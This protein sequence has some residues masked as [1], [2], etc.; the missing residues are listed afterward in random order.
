MPLSDRDYMKPQPPEPR[1][2]PVIRGGSGGFL[3]NPVYIIIILNI[4]VYVA[5]LVNSTKLVTTFGLMPATFTQEPWTLVTNMFVHVEI[6]HILGNMLMLFFFGRVVYQLI[7]TKWFL[8]IYF[9]GG[10]AGNLLYVWLGE[11]YA[12]AIG[13]SA[14]IYALAG[15]LVVMMP[16]MRVTLWGIIPMPLWAFVLVFLV[17]WS[18]PGF[19]PGIAWQGHLGGLAVGLIAGFIFRRITRYVFYR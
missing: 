13:A 16:T 14:A 19:I 4:I 5:S 8:L 7:G 11:P 18:I 6:W 3:T 1:R 17:L 10:I 12:T 2:R 15:A 9:L